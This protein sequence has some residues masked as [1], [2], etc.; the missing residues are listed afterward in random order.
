MVNKI[1]SI[2]KFT[3]CAELSYVSQLL[4]G[5]CF[6]YLAETLSIPTE[7]ELK[8]MFRPL[9]VS[10]LQADTCWERKAAGPWDT[11]GKP[12]GSK[13]SYNTARSVQQTEAPK[14]IFTEATPFP[15][16]SE[17]WARW[18]SAVGLRGGEP[19]GTWVLMRR[20]VGM[21]TQKLLLEQTHFARLYSSV[22]CERL[23]LYHN[24]ICLIKYL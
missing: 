7:L 19:Q 6:F 20:N 21:D 10:T 2:S 12:T 17:L 16:S 5:Q 18:S 4:V 1:N 22:K 15:M 11:W 14:A 23:F 9:T 24:V 13:Y 3:T 8:A